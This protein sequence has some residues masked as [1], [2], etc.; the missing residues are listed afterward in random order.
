MMKLPWPLAAMPEVARAGRYAH[1]DRDFSPGYRCGTH[2]LH[3][4]DYAADMTLADRRLRLSPGDITLTPAGCEARYHLEEPGFHWCIHFRPL[5][6]AQGP[7]VELPL[8]LPAGA[9]RPRA[10]ETMARIGQWMTAAEG[11]ALPAALASVGLQELLLGLAW[12]AQQ[13]TVRQVRAVKAA[14]AVAAMLDA[15]LANPPSMTAL[16]QRVALSPT[17][18]ARAFR[19]RYGV[20]AAR[21]LLGRRI[22]EAVHLLSTT[23]LPVGRIARRLGFAD[24]QHFNKQFRRTL[25]SAPTDYRRHNGSFEHGAGS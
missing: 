19:A 12:E 4:Y 21:Y 20:T 8:H 10:V 5:A 25:G 14:E 23:D 2:A 22:E 15:A 16:A 17:H 1:E 13:P 18:L 3:L 9:W 6:S 7:Q 11:D 24:A